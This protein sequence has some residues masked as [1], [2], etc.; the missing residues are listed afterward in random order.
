MVWWQWLMFSFVAWLT[1]DAL[2]ALLI[3]FSTKPRKAT[4]AASGTAPDS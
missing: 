4:R 1:A 3:G 2:F